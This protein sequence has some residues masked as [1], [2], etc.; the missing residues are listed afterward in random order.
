[1]SIK[2]DERNER[3]NYKYLLHKLLNE[4]PH[5]RYKITLRHLPNKIG[6]ST[7]T[8]RKWRYIK[9]GDRAMIPADKLA[10][11]ANYFEITIEEIFNFNIPKF[12]FEELEKAE[13]DEKNNSAKK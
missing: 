5:N 11:I 2:I 10:I 3:S 12:S 1:M 13:T 9:K 7:D 8:F 6:V 4:L